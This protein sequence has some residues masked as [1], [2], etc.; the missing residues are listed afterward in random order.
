MS[1]GVSEMNRAALRRREDA[2]AL[3][4]AGHF[5]GAMYVSGYA[6]ECLL[7]SKLM[8]MFDCKTLDALEMRLRG[9]GRM[10]AN[11]SIYTHQLEYLLRLTGRLEVLQQSVQGVHFRVINAWLPAW[12]YDPRIGTRKESEKFLQSIDAI[13]AW[14]GNNV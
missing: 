2:E 12:R 1:D 6:I 14:V 11:A 10:A 4:A 13:M 9:M 5:R 8:K 7:K 3:L